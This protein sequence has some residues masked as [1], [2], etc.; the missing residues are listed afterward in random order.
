MWRWILAVLALHGAV[1]MAMVGATVWQIQGPPSLRVGPVQTRWLAPQPPPPANVPAPKAKV[2]RQTRLGTVPQSAASPAASPTASPSAPSSSLS[3][4][5]SLP[6]PRAGAQTEPRAEPP[7]QSLDL[8]ERAQTDMAREP[9]GTGAERQVAPAQSAQSPL[10]A[11][12]DQAPVSPTQAAGLAEATM[13]LPPLGLA[14]LPASALLS[15]RLNGQEKGIPYQA[16]G[17]LRWER[18]AGAYAMSLS[19]RAFLLGS[20]QWRSQGLITAQGLSPVRFS[21]SWRSE[22]ATHFEAAQNRIVFSSNAPAATLQPGAQDQISLYPQ[23][24]ALMAQEAGR[25]QPGTRLQVQTATVRDALPWLLTLEQQETLQIDGQ[26]LTATKWVCQP[27]N[28]FDAKVEFWVAAQQD[29]L[30]VRIRI[31]QVSGSFIDLLL[32]GRVALPD[33]SRTPHPG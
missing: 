2:E 1:W 10:Q 13:A 3:P 31:T 11:P 16:T 25:L 32:T 24:A 33:L 14:A 29:W 28:R 23:M 6:V 20:R 18:N 4:D 17:E 26:N 27:R 30:P 21:D 22:R 5:V 15:Y 19:V 8:S 9:E 7:Q 12:A